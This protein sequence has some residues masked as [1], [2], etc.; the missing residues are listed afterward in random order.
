MMTKAAAI[1][2]AFDRA[3]L[4][5]EIDG[6]SVEIYRIMYQYKALR[7]LPDQEFDQVYEDLSRR[8]GFWRD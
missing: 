7:D 4:Q 2:R 1:E 8:L 5:A 6:E 3:N